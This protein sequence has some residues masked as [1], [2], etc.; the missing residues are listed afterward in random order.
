MIRAPAATRRPYPPAAGPDGSSPA[1]RA[2]TSPAPGAGTRPAPGA[3]TGSASAAGSGSGAGSGPGNSGP[4]PARGT[5]A[6][7]A[8]ARRRRPAARPS[9]HDRGRPGGRP[10]CARPPAGGRSRSRSL[11]GRA[12]LWPALGQLAGPAR[13]RLADQRHRTLPQR[14]PVQRHDIVLGQPEHRGDPLALK[15]QL[16]QR[17]NRHLA[18]RGVGRAVVEQH[19]AARSDHAPA[20][21]LAGA[22]REARA[23]PSRIAAAKKNRTSGDARLTYFRRSESW[24][25]SPTRRANSRCRTCGCCSRYY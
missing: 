20:S 23:C 12:R 14:R 24:P 18:H 17:R 11:P 21:H 15:P 2:G 1:A 25:C 19:P 16:A 8:A 6:R 10:W 3:G 5:A 4:D 7:P 9:R 13:P 22:D